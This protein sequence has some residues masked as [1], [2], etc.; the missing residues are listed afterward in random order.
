MAGRTVPKHVR[1]YADGYDFSGFSRT[2]GPLE[3]VY[4]E[5]DLT[6]QMGDAAK[7]FF[8]NL[9][10]VK[11]GTLNTVLDNTPT[12]GPHII[13][14]TVE[15]SRIVMVPIGIQAAPVSGDP[16]FMGQF[17]QGGYTGEIVDKSV[18]AN[19][20]FGE[21]DVENEIAYDKP[22]GKL[23]HPKGAET[24]ANTGTSDVDNGGAS[25]AGGWLMYHVFDGN[26]TA[27]ISIDDAATDSN[28]SYA[29]LSGATSGEINCAVVQKGIVALGVGATVRQ[30]LRWQISLNT[31]TTV[32]FALAFVR[33]N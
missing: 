29:A 30:Y 33:G 21:W 19:A 18:Y 20:P 13:L 28:P 24:G 4:E 15:A 32:T 14:Q 7:G 26:G 25:A 17:V 6:A 2:I 23:V 5:A 11:L 22:W 16:V 9:A 27:T 31:A 12:S 3:W 8:P 1:V 10:S